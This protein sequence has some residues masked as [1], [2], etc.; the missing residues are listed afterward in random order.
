MK[1]INLFTNEVEETYE[2]LVE[3]YVPVQGNLRTNVKIP[4]D[5]KRVAIH[6]AKNLLKIKYFQ[7][8]KAFRL[9]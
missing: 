2:F 4:R 9:N 5:D 6:A 7:Q 3:F 1:Q 8:A